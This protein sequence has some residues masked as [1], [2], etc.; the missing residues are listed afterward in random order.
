MS[1]VYY[2]YVFIYEKWLSVEEDGG[3]LDCVIPVSN[4]ADI[5]TFSYLC[6]ANFRHNITDSHLWMSVAIRPEKS[7]F[8]RAQRLSCCLALLFLTMIANAMFYGQ[9]TGSKITIGPIKFSLTGIYISLISALV[10]APPVLLVTY[11]FRNARHMKPGKVQ[12]SGIII[13][14][15]GL[16]YACRFVAWAIVTAAIIV[17]GY[18]L[19]LY[20]ME[21]GK[22][23]SE[24]WLV[25]F[26]LSFMESV[27]IVDPLKVS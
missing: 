25:S 26:F 9:D 8:T 19:I 17:S 2:R 11:L 18:F 22:V 13:T 20:S 1:I 4:K 10:A 27:F 7:N 21:W 24:G 15:T 3:S 14:P 23:K 12:G 6:N 5:T 16:P